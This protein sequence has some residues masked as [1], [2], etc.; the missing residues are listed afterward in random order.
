ME[1][2]RTVL[3]F[4]L[5]AASTAFAATRLPLTITNVGG[6]SDGVGVSQGRWTGQPMA[7]PI[8]N[9]YVNYQVV[10][11]PS[12]AALN[13]TTGSTYTWTITG[14]NFGSTKGSVWVLDP[15]MNS[16]PGLS[17]T[18]QSWSDTKIVVIANAPHT[19]TSRSDTSLWVSRLSTRPAPASNLDW[20]NRALPIVGLIQSRGHGQ[21][22]WFVA[23]TRLAQ[24]LRIPP[25]AYTTTIN[26]S[27]IGGI[28]NYVPAQWDALSY[29]T[30][31]VA[32]ITSPVTRSPAGATNGAITYSFTVSEM[33]ALTDEA[34]SSSPRV[35]R[36]S[37]VNAKGQ[38]TVVQ[39]I[40]SN[41]GSS[42]VATG[43]YR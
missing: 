20:S 29:G 7:R 42:Y 3:A 30:R 14:T 15:S 28:D 26:L 11:A 27:G 34:E 33:N 43:C 16:V 19:F 23:K 2:R 5:G 38:R 22:T 10:A 8:S 35:Y 18:I 13:V 1:N 32:I 36:V 37:A 40:G 31:H 9:K 12:N 41:A 25:S 39:M 21:C 24:G 4:G 17:I 6:Y